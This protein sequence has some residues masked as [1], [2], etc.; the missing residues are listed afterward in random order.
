[1]SPRQRLA[2]VAAAVVVLV[3]GFVIASGS[4]DDNSASTTA[5]STTDVA[6]GTDV[7]DTTTT[8]ATPKPKPRPA[9]PTVVVSGGK[10]QG[11]IKKLSFA[12]GSRA[13]FTVRSDVA[14]EIHLH[15][16]DLMKDVKAGGSVTFDLTANIDGH[17]VVELEGAGVQIAQLE[18]TP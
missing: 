1:M 12:K 8:A 18:V 16:Y 11:G 4:S 9:I 10:P 13:R 7:A 15:G 6:T 2:I 3:A 14:D 17:F 5:A